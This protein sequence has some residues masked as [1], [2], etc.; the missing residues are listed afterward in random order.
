MAPQ[1]H[2]MV[3]NDMTGRS[4]M[5]ESLK[6]LPKIVK[7]QERP[8][9]FRLLDLPQEVVDMVY[10][11]MLRVGYIGILCTSHQVYR[12]ASQFLEREAVLRLKAQASHDTFQCYLKSHKEL[13]LKTM[14]WVQ[15]IEIR[16]SSVISSEDFSRIMPTWTPRKHRANEIGRMTYNADYDKPRYDPFSKST[17]PLVHRNTCN[18]IL[19][20]NEFEIKEIATQR[21]FDFFKQLAGFARLSFVY[22][23]RLRWRFIDPR[24]R[25]VTRA[26]LITLYQVIRQQLEPIMGPGVPIDGFIDIGEGLEFHPLAHQRTGGTV[27][28]PPMEASKTRNSLI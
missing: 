5:Q 12:R 11:Q 3:K 25:S 9:R 22:E 8:T 1:T 7:V 14:Y 27:Q 17:G 10:I 21:T 6:G 28:C 18:I 23:F 19:P 2:S 15:N 4:G 24:K 13:D 16:L 20:Y 26:T